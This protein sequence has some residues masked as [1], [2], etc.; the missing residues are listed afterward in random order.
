[1]HLSGGGDALYASDPDHS[2]QNLFS[3]PF[4]NADDFKAA[5]DGM[6]PYL[7]EGGEP[8]SG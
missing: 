3:L 5:I 8:Y 4:S 6:K 1:M 7:A 2:R